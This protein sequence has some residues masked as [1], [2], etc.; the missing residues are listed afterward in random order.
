MKSNLHR[1]K[2]IQSSLRVSSE[3]VILFNPA[4]KRRAV[5]TRNA[6]HE[7]PYIL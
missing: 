6:V 4:D 2:F 7:M 1:S 3:V 5:P